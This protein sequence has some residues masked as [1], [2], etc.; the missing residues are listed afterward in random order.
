MVIFLDSDWR[1][2]TSSLPDNCRLLGVVSYNSIITGA[3]VKF[4]SRTK[5]SKGMLYAI[6]R[7]GEFFRVDARKIGK[8]I[9]G[10]GQPS[11]PGKTYT[12]KLSDDHVQKARAIGGGSRKMSQGVRESIEKYH[13]KKT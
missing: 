12:I 10:I 1:K 3:L 7:N 5:A 13:L 6:V 8:G 4:A 9:T 2:Y 11:K